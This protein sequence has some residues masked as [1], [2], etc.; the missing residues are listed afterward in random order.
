MHCHSQL[1]DQDYSFQLGLEHPECPQTACCDGYS[2]KW[3]QMLAV[4]L[5]KSE[6]HT[7]TGEQ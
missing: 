4:Q 6:P 1:D 2:G 5:G 7:T 3:L